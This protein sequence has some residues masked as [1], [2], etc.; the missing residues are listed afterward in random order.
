MVASRARITATLYVTA[1]PPDTLFSSACR[2]HLFRL[3]PLTAAAGTTR[4]CN[5]LAEAHV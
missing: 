1:R 4:W 2:I 5:V 3:M